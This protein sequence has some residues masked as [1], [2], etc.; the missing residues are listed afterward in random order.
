MVPGLATRGNTTRSTLS[1]TTSSAAAVVV[2]TT[3]SSAATTILNPR[4][5]IELYRLV[6][7][8]DWDRVL[9]HLGEYP[10]EARFLDDFGLSPLHRA[11]F[12]DAPLA[13]VAALIQAFPEATHMQ[14]QCQFSGLTPLHAACH[15]CSTAVVRCLL[16]S[17]P[18]A[19]HR[20]STKGH[21]PLQC[22][23]HVYEARI[24][25]HFARI[26]YE[27]YQQSKQRRKSNTWDTTSSSSCNKIPTKPWSDIF[28]D[29][30]ILLRF[31]GVVCSLLQVQVYG[32]PETMNDSSYD[33]SAFIV[34]ACARASHM[35][36]TIMLELAVKLHPEQLLIRC[37]STGQLPLHIALSQTSPTPHSDGVASYL[38]QQNPTAAKYPDASGIYPLI[39]AQSAGK[40]WNTFVYP[41]LHANP[42]ALF[43]TNPS[44]HLL[45]TIMGRVATT[46]TTT[47]NNTNSNSKRLFPQKLCNPIK[48]MTDE[49]NAAVVSTLF[50]LLRENPTLMDVHASGAPYGVKENVEPLEINKP[51]H[52]KSSSSKVSSPRSIILC[53]RMLNN[54]R[55]SCKKVQQIKD[56]K[57]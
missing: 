18:S 15:Y 20:L 11:C 24:R 35:V 1:D 52:S 17:N 56:R 41:L 14:D 40:S 51:Q 21:T 27:N 30:P 16:Q 3:S 48:V 7:S 45:T 22:T 34:H 6:L 33:Y 4:S 39:Q 9:R 44:C 5:P 25:H 8:R 50:G 57:T 49:E 38:F 42:V 13:V 37:K 12:R 26:E 32:C 43:T 54:I 10:E 53:V 47:A 46:T 23:C 29:D 55:L 2:T 36:P 28:V 31:W 19:I